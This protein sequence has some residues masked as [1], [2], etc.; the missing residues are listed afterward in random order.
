MN[1][2]TKVIAQDLKNRCKGGDFDSIKEVMNTLFENKL[3]A[4]RK[5][6]EDVRF[7]QGYLSALE[8]LGSIL[9]KP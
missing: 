9:S 6:E 8:E 3:I 5:N 2:R 1:E 4:L 7:N